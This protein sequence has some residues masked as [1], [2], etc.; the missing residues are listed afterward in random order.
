MRSP[1]FDRTRTFMR[2][3]IGH[4]SNQGYMA[5]DRMHRCA[6]VEFQDYDRTKWSCRYYDDVAY[7]I[8][9]RAE[10]RPNSKHGKPT[11]YRPMTVIPEADVPQEVV[12]FAKAE[13]VRLR[14]LGQIQA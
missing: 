14:L 7:P 3:R 6:G 12:E 4:P 1:A 5:G 2:G 9:T 8:W 10:L 13:L 11:G